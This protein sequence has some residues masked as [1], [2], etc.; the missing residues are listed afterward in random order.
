MGAVLDARDPGPTTKIREITQLGADVVYETK[1]N[2]DLSIVLEV[3][4]R[5]SGGSHWTGLRQC[6]N[7]DGAFSNEWHKDNWESWI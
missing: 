5:G 2:P 4:R 3:A 6:P 7:T 1:P